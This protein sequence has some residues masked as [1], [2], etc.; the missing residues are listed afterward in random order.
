MAAMEGPPR[1]SQ[2]RKPMPLP[3]VHCFFPSG[4]LL[5]GLTRVARGGILSVREQSSNEMALFGRPFHRD[6]GRKRHGKPHIQFATSRGSE[7]QAFIA[8]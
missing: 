8:A 1:R 3:P 7:V 4:L 2:P 5:H 6:R